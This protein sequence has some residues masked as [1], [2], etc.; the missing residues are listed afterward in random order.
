[1]AAIKNVSATQR[2]SSMAAFMVILTL[3]ASTV[4]SASD[5]GADV[6]GL[7]QRILRRAKV[8]HI[9]VSYPKKGLLHN[10]QF[11][12]P[13]L[14]L[15][16]LVMGGLVGPL[17]LF[18]VSRLSEVGTPDRLGAEPRKAPGSDKKSN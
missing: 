14:L 3:A 17:A 11:L 8:E 13:G 18:I 15:A 10:Y 7:G 16:I 12:S 6:D 9:P 5:A 1:M 2:I 4:A